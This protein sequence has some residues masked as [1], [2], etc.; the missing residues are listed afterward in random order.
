ML[1]HSAVTAATNAR[2][3]ATTLGRRAFFELA[4][5]LLRPA[6]AAPPRALAASPARACARAL[7]SRPH[8][9]IDHRTAGNG[10]ES[11]RQPAEEDFMRARSR[12]VRN[13]V[14]VALGLIV[15]CEGPTGPAGPAGDSGLP[16]DPGA[17]GSQGD[18]G[19]AGS[20]GDIGPTGA[21]GT[22]G[23]PGPTGP[24]G[25]PGDPGPTGPIGVSVGS[26]TGTVT[27]GDTAL[28]IAS[29]IVGTQPPTMTAPSAA[30]GSYTLADIPIGVYVVEVSATGYGTTTIGTVSVTAGGT[31]I[32]DVQLFVPPVTLGSV[33][34]T[35]IRRSP[36]DDPVAGATVALV[37]AFAL[38]ASQ[39]EQPLEDLAAAS[40]YFAITDLA[41][42]YVIADVPPGLYYAHVMPDA[43]DADDV[44]PGGDVSRESIAVSAGQDT[45]LDIVV[46]QRPSSAA[47]YVGSSTCL[48]CH[49]GSPAT[50][51]TGWTRTLHALVYRVPDTP[52]ANQDLSQLPDHD[53]AHTF[54]KDST[55][56]PANT[57]D[58]TGAGDEYGLRIDNA[59][60]PMF[61]AA[62]NL[63]LGHDGAY[64]VQFEDP[65]GPTLSMKYY[66]AFTFGGHGV[67]KE[68]WVT[69][70]AT[71]G[72]HD[73][74][75]GGDS[76]Y[77]VLP[78]QYDEKLQPGVEPFHPYNAANWGPPAMAGGPAVRP[79]QNKSFDNNCA[80]CHFTGTAL[81]RD[82]MGNFL[83]DAAD[84][85]AGVMDYDGD[86]S[87]DEM[88]IGCEACH[89]PGSE[90]AS[91]PGPGQNI[92]VPGLLSAERAN[93]VC[94]SC[95]TRGHGI[96]SLGGDVTEYPSAGT[97]PLTF[98]VPGMSRD[99][100]VTGFHVDNPGLYADDTGHSRQHHQQYL[101]F[102]KSGHYRNPYQLLTCGDCHD[103]HNRDIGRSLSAP[104]DDN[105]LCLNCHAPYT[106]G[107]AAPW[108]GEQEALSVSEH[109]TDYADMTIG[110]DPTNTAGVAPDTATG[111]VGQC[112]GCHMPRT[113][114]SQSRFIYDGV[115]A[116]LQPAGSRVRGDVSSHVFDV[117]M[118][119]QSQ[120]LYIAGGANNQMPNSCASCHNTLGGI[121]PDYA[122]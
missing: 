37:D 4:D 92:V 74:T 54:F 23:D 83:A 55:V 51:A 66:V 13:L 116:Q 84:D 49:D 112:A 70:V 98:P 102:L 100:F 110:Y 25:G 42:A 38:A 58:N 32:V 104:A 95:H 115:N 6:V 5:D 99:E 97:G 64:F 39:S 46:S 85:P 48:G 63:L 79:A 57:R 35:V 60:F 69:R 12:L 36:T 68:R 96:G 21:N 53:F 59:G 107:L 88:V 109:M 8:A 120:A 44:L 20:Q 122:Y 119:A 87:L 67:Y 10:L 117:I 30:D 28:P 72:S 65:A 14:V 94:G 26:I 22:S 77:Y 2:W 61:P 45:A 43:L 56:E 106:F 118:P 108:T 15:G 9:G 111:G 80:G 103:L 34:G 47:T 89:G 73:P 11:A 93:Q 75:A 3:R 40:L 81:S 17:A 113:A 31:R 50:D 62:Y 7:L 27:D 16:G 90:H 24:Q 19:A 29:A 78:V 114:A 91:G 18:R 41:G 71:D 82:G 76:S 33:S 121:A 52:T 101:D 1:E 105:T 86:S